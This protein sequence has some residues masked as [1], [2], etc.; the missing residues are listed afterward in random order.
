MT[1]EERNGG[2]GMPFMDYVKEG[3]RW[4]DGMRRKE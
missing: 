4:G 1:C 2:D 3:A